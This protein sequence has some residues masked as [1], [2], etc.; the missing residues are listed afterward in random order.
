MIQPHTIFLSVFC[1]LT[2]VG[3]SSAPDQ[4]PSEPAVDRI[5]VHYGP[6]VGL[7]VDVP[8]LGAEDAQC[9]E[10][11]TP[12]TISLWLAALDAIPEMPAQGVRLVSFVGDPPE[13]RIELYS[14][15]ELRRVCRMKAGLLDVAAYD[16]WAFYSGE[17]RAFT[18]LVTALVPGT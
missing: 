6:S 14:G 5:V 3:C 12:E 18:S 16:G 9:V 8:Q 15:D 11:R 13:H 17:D 1:C 7:A 2:A 4:P 10:I